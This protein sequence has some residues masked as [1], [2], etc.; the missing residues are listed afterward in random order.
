MLVKGKSTLETLAR[1]KS[2]V[3]FT[4][5]DAR[6]LGVSA[7]LLDYYVKKGEL[8]RLSRGIYRNAKTKTNLELRW[9]DLIIA[10]LTIPEGAVCL[11]SALAVYGLT[12]EIPRE[13]WIAIPHRLRASRRSHVRCVRMRDMTIGKTEINLGG[14]QV[15]IF[16]RERTVVDAFR[17]LGREAAI[18]ALKMYFSQGGKPRPDIRKLREYAKKLRVP[19]EPYLMTVTT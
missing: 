8:Q 1:F 15:P 4:A 7:A 14:T 2:R 11:L 16:D 5:D 9:E 17:Y 12:E 10:A 6:K 3:L 19:I 18:K 13:H